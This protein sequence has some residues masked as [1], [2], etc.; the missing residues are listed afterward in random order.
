[1]A[2]LRTEVAALSAPRGTVAATT[3]AAAS[4]T[5]VAAA[6]TASAP[7]AVASTAS[8]S[9]TGGAVATAVPVAEASAASTVPPSIVTFSAALP[10]VPVPIAT[11]FVACGRGSPVVSHVAFE[12]RGHPQGLI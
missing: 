7:V 6:R 2:G 5:T 12:R 8:V 3:S 10:A 1:M 4:S 11:I 9:P